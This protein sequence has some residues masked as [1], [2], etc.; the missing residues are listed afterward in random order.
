MLGNL[1]HE[2]KM[3]GQFGLV[4]GATVG[5]AL[6]EGTA[7]AE[8]VKTLSVQFAA[9]SRSEHEDAGARL[10]TDRRVLR[11]QRT[12]GH[13]SRASHPKTA[14]V[15]DAKWHLPPPPHTRTD[16]A[17]PRTL[18]GKKTGSLLTSR[19]NRAQTLQIQ[20]ALDAHHTELVPDFLTLREKRGARAR[21]R[22]PSRRCAN[23]RAH[24]PERPP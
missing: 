19:A 5:Q 14:S 4:N 13:V 20:L 11:L 18:E 22:P 7:S 2:A 1:Q 21:R 16:L 12:Y 23:N 9:A 17:W 3:L 24:S 15:S 10:D 8:L 6:H